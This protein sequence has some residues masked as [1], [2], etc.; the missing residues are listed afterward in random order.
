LS[1]LACAPRGAAAGAGTREQSDLQEQTN[2][3]KKE[4]MFQNKLLHQTSM[5]RNK[6]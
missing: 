5:N 4:R 3:Q 2:K 6:T 1:E